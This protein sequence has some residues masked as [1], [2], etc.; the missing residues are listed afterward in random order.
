MHVSAVKDVPS[1]AGIKNSVRGHWKRGQHPDQATFV[2][3][4]KPLFARCYTPNPTAAGFEVIEHLVW[5]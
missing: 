4:Q 2:I 3:P 5:C 1:A